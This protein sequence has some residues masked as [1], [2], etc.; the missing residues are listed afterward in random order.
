MY[1]NMGVNSP[2]S[3]CKPPSS[4]FYAKQIETSIS[5]KPVAVVKHTNK[6]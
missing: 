2:V 4:Q 3:Y 6:L 1:E 5:L